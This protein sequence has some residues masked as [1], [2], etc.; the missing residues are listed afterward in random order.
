MFLILRFILELPDQDCSVSGTGD[1][2]LGVFI[3]F[4]RVA[5]DNG[6]DP[7]VVTNEVTFEGKVDVLG[8]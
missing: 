2:D 4:D 6:C 3:L 8:L 7:T 1:E 5:G